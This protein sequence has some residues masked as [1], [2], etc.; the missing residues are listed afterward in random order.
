MRGHVSGVGAVVWPGHISEIW[1]LVVRNVFPQLCQHVL[2]SGGECSFL[3]S[4][5]DA[6]SKS[7]SV[8]AVVSRSIILEQNV[9][10]SR[11]EQFQKLLGL[12]ICEVD[13]GLVI[14][15]VANPPDVP[16]LHESRV[17]I[18]NGKFVVLGK[19]T[20]ATRGANCGCHKTVLDTINEVIADEMRE[21]LDD[22]D[23]LGATTDKVLAST[24]KRGYPLHDQSY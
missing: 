12:I 14:S 6:A 13:H 15:S 9:R 8:H 17:R 10:S 16:G 1:V 24:F 20:I 2:G 4:V 11:L 7:P 5:L 22:L 21:F 18:R 23:K 3:R 19:R